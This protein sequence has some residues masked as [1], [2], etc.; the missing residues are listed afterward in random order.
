MAASIR[1]YV[2]LAKEIRDTYE[3]ADDATKPLIRYMVKNMCTALKTDNPNF[4]VDRFQMASTGI[5][6]AEL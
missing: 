2:T 1:L 5:V 6:E 3:L 4:D